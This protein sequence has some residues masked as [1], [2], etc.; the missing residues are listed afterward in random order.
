MYKTFNRQ[1]QEHFNNKERNKQTKLFLLAQ[2]KEDIETSRIKEFLQ[3][4]KIKQEKT[5]MM[6]S[7]LELVKN[8]DA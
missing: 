7:S 8:V 4:L 1:A 3:D 6:I 2:Q 5:F